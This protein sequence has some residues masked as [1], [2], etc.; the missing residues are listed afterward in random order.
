M[1]QDLALT[2]ETVSAI[3]EL[4]VDIVGVAPVERFENRLRATAH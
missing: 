3:L 1:K 2:K 4:G